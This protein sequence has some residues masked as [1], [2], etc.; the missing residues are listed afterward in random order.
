MPY[1]Q[2]WTFTQAGDWNLSDLFLD[3]FTFNYVI[4]AWPTYYS[5]TLHQN[6]G[7]NGVGT[8]QGNTNNVSTQVAGALTGDIA[9]R[10][11]AFK[12]VDFSLS[13]QNIGNRYYVMSPGSSTTSTPTLAMPFNVMGGVR[14]DW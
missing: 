6:Y 5:S 7:A 12:Q 9:F 10:Y 3:G 8:G 2:P 4:K 11:K 14:I 13:I 1:V